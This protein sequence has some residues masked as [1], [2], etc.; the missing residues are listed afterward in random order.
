MVGQPEDGAIT[1]AVDD[2]E[3]ARDLVFAQKGHRLSFALRLLDPS[4][5][6]PP[7]LAGGIMGGQGGLV[8][9]RQVIGLNVI[10]CI[11]ADRFAFGYTRFP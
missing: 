5:P 6:G 10:G 11:H 4:K 2:G 8:S 9:A 1:G 7:S 3:Q